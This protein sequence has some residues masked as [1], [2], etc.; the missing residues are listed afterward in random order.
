M[1][2]TCC[3]SCSACWAVSRLFSRLAFWAAL[4]ASADSNNSVFA[5]SWRQNT[6]TKTLLLIFRQLFNTSHY[7]VLLYWITWASSWA[8]FSLLSV[9]WA[10]SSVTEFS[11]VRARSWAERSRVFCSWTCSC[12]LS[13]ACLLLSDWFFNLSVSCATYTL[14]HTENVMIQND[15]LF[16]VNWIFEL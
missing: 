12:K 5:F 8:T 10:V 13:W 9:S 7:H 14:P 4:V 16:P 6:S 3:L 1:N 11:R 2:L 15:Q